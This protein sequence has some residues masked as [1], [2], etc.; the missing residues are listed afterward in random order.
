MLRRYRRPL[1][2][3][4]AVSA[5]IAST[6][7][8]ALSM[9]TLEIEAV[10]ED[11]R[12]Y[13]DEEYQGRGMVSYRAPWGL[14]RPYQ[15]RVEGR[16]IPAYEVTVENEL[17]LPM[18]GASALLVAA[19]AT[20][21][22][23]GWGAPDLVQKFAFTVAAIAFGTAPYT[24]LAHN[25]FPE[26]L[27]IDANARRFVGVP[28]ENRAEQPPVK[29]AGLPR[30]SVAYEILRQQHLRRVDPRKLERAA[31]TA[32]LTEAGWAD[33]LPTY[34]ERIDGRPFSSLEAAYQAISEAQE[35]PVLELEAIQ[36]MLQALDRPRPTWFQ[37]GDAEAAEPQG[38]VGMTIGL[39]N[40]QL[41]VTGTVAGS[42]ASGADIRPGDRLLAI[43]RRT[44]DTLDPEEAVLLLRGPEGT[45]VPLKLQR[46]DAPPVERVL[47]REVLT[48]PAIEVAMLEEGLALIS[49]PR[50]PEGAEIA[51]L[52]RRLEE[53]EGAR[54]VV[55]DL[56]GN[57]GGSFASVTHLMG[58]LDGVGPVLKTVGRSS[59]LLSGIKGKH[60]V[61]AGTPMVILVDEATAGT[62]ETLACA[63]QERRRA[64]V[65]GRPTARLGYWRS[66]H[67]LPGG[68]L[69][70]VVAGEM[71]TPG[72]AVIN[73]EGVV[74]DVAVEAG[75]GDPVLEA[76]R[77]LF[78]AGLSA[79]DLVDQ[80]R[81]KGDPASVL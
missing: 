22:W 15:V 52:E 79:R 60:R 43:G 29:V 62:A 19:G 28:R 18:A 16:S 13:V 58:R 34:L 49:M 63:L 39:R 33:R 38:S 54:G 17:N 66:Y 14:P 31:L 70:T 40:G 47:V 45:P 55:V 64:V 68:D 24:L 48:P 26:D 32:M 72:G 44:T 76:A 10:P 25:G 41:V 12:I 69:M 23:L 2:S 81:R 57:E 30:L 75:E 78:D 5:L 35:N 20:E 21:V 36:A 61:P 1:A 46:G 3:F 74:P 37:A 56:R 65:V 4:L 42:Q 71:L 11:A 77:R 7:C 50:M 67:R 9:T 59:Y 73:D 53:H 27:R 6:G 8:S 51:S 80:Y